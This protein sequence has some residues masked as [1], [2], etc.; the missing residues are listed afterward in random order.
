MRKVGSKTRRLSQVLGSVSVQGKFK[1][2][3]L[4]LRRE[5]I[6][7]SNK[8][9]IHKDLHEENLME[10]IGFFLLKS[11][12]ECLREKEGIRYEIYCGRGGS[13]GPWPFEPEKCILEKNRRENL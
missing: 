8:F 6:L 5:K 12:D 2:G 9:K 7:L 1:L 13:L 11:R 10:G 3:Q 4:S